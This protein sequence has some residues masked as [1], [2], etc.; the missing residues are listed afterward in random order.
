MRLL[1]VAAVSLLVSAGTSE[2]AAQQESARERA[3]RQSREAE[4]RCLADPF[5]GITTDGIPLTGLFPVRSTGVSTAPVQAAASAFLKSLTP[6]QHAKTLFS[7]DNPEWRKWMNQHFYVRQG[8]GFKEMSESQ[9]D[10]AFALLGASLSAKGLKLSR[11][12]MRLNHTLGELT[13]NFDE[14]GEWLYWIT[15][16][17]E[18]S[19][20]EPWG[21]Q[22]DGHHL[23]INYFVLGDQ[24]V[25]TPM[26]VGSE[27]VTTT[28]GKYQGVSILQQEQQDAL[29]LVN[30]LMPNQRKAAVLDSAKAGFNTLTEAFRDNV[31]LDYAGVSARSFSPVQRRQLLD[32]IGLFVGNMREGH[33]KVRMAEVEAH[34]D[35][36]HFAWIGQTEADA[37]FYYRI[38]S[39]V[40]LI[41]FDHQRPIALR[42]QYGTGPTRQ[43]IHA[44]VRTPNG[45]DYGKD[46]LREHHRRHKH[47]H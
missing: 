26:F 17:G 3:A 7:D 8:V 12:I 30:A 32:L 21:W 42:Q 37:V 41:E 35:Q 47:P 33:A 27:P 10:A 19:E 43:H 14:Y 2:L 46:L 11:D 20:T 29:A 45:N 9:R 38:H 6:V 25:M 23:I 28:T 22:L 34:L 15:I 4:A 24:V 5:K 39:P 40:I 13:N 44:V 16:M 36:T 1:A 31:V 18:P